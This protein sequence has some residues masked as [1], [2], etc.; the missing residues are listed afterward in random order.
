MDSM[1]TVAL[2]PTRSILPDPVRAVIFDM[3]GTLIDTEAVHLRAFAEA[4]EALGW[5][6]SE[7]FLLSLVGIY[8]DQNMVTFRE[9]FGPDFPL[10]R[11][12][13]ESDALFEAAMAASVP[14][15]LGAKA[16]LE[17][18]A[19]LGIRMA[20]ATSTMAPYAQHRLNSAGLLHYFQAVVTRTD[21]EFPKPNPQPY[22]MAADRLGVDP[23]HCVAVEDSYAGVRAATAAGIATV[24]IPDL[25]PPT[26]ELVE[27]CAA[28]LPSL[29]DLGN[30]LVTQVAS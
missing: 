8:R 3:D 23:A 17:H 27:V 18:F 20:V 5:P 30:L 14:L 7:E 16:V 22:L 25:L 1:A 19:A 10:E 29:S 12:Y 15:K 26:D 24:M 21:V 2:S 9:T 13:A 28:V 11:F 4:G 6:L